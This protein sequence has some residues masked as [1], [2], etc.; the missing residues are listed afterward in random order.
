MKYDEAFQ[1]VHLSERE[2]G[3]LALKGGSANQLG[4]VKSSW[5]GR[6]LLEACLVGWCLALII[7]RLERELQLSLLIHLIKL[8]NGE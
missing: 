1:V 6:L 3:L 5:K 8:L 4:S 2:E 7:F